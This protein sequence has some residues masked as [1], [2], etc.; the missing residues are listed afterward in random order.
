[1][2]KPHIVIIGAGAMGCLFGTGLREAG[3]AVTLVVRTPESAHALN[4]SG[5]R[6][7]GPTGSRTVTGILATTD[8][9][10]A[11]NA[12]AVL[13]LV[14]APATKTVAA[15]LAPHLTPNTL[16]LTLQNGLGNMEAL[17]AALPASQVAA[18]ITGN[19][20][21]L[22]GVGHIRLGGLAE[23]VLG[24]LEGGFPAR[25]EALG[26]I[27]GKARFP[28]RISENITGAMWTKLL[29][30]V[31][32]N[33]V[34]ALTGLRNGGII[35][36]RDSFCVAAAAVREAAKV[37]DALGVRLE[38]DDPVEHMRRAGE[39][40]AANEN[41][42]LQDLRAGRVTEIEAMNGEIERRGT[43]LGIPVP[44]NATLA[45]LVRSRQ[46]AFTA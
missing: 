16:V 34:G 20:A 22:L 36:G 3:C 18:G 30:N 6:I 35:T 38:T 28:V 13:V 29:V 7:E 21:T 39:L 2:A 5:I 23:T 8:Y 32:I 43:A 1:M 15:S 46:K 31:G 9:A 12:S 33:P 27:L 42:M 41:S 4:A 37:A 45:S 14:K 26:A 24:E 25:L 44:V 40:T 19:G 11:A 10:A 17:C